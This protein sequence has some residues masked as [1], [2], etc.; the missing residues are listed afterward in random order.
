LNTVSTDMTVADFCNAFTRREIVVNRDYQR[1]DKVWPD[2]AKSFLVETLILGYPMPKL[3]MHQ[4][5]DVA[6]RQTTKEI[7]DGQ[8]RASTIVQFFKDE[9]KLSNGLETERIAGK[10]LSD[11]DSDDQASFLDY[12]ISMDLFIAAP[13][14]EVREVFRRMNSYT[15]PLN[16]EEQ[17]HAVYQGLFKWFIYH[18]ARQYSPALV[19]MGGFSEKQIVRM[20]DAKLLTE[21]SHALLN[22]ITTTS[23]AKLDALYKDKDRDFPEE[24]DLQVRLAAS[25]DMIIG[26]E[27]IHST[28][29]MK[30]YHLY[31]LILAI[32]HATEPV[33]ALTSI[34]AGGTGLVD[35][36]DLL[37]NLSWLNEAL[38]AGED[39]A[40]SRPYARFVQASS[41]KTNTAGSRVE[42][43]ESMF[44]AVTQEQL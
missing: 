42:R 4:I 26:W 23:K 36:T 5:T 38:D 12:A 19:R 21:L 40:A 30:P 22:G 15:V 6:T 14:E 44:T 11:L 3:S 1:S 35:R 18:L 9:L 34:V 37:R 39:G 43:F 28:R 25:L 24:R 2:V 8:Q 31:S 10:R 33:P 29:L 17:R 13:P 20:N 41:S 16:P 27:D 7:V 32:T